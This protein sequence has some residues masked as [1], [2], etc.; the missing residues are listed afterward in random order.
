MIRPLYS[1][2]DYY[3]QNISFSFESDTLERN[4]SSLVR[5]EERRK[6][7]VVIQVDIIDCQSIR[8]FRSH[9]MIR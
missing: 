7:V 8:V 2:S 5:R 3:F 6:K 9:L 4:D 1:L